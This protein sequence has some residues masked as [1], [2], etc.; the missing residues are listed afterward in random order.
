MERMKH[1]LSICNAGPSEHLAT[2]ALK[3]RDAVI[4]RNLELLRANVEA[5]DRFFAA[6]PDRFEWRR[7]DGG[8]TAFPRYRG[9]DGV[10]SFCRRLLEEAGVVLLP[11][12][13]Y[14]SSLTPTPSD[15]FRIG[16][17]RDYT[18]AGLDVMREFMARIPT[19][20]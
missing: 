17:G 5:V 9:A 7:P 11:A 6:F 13:I 10:E 1:Y 2:I 16:F 15:R 18:R 8:C 14:R 4:G 3:A 20:R 19:G 12:S